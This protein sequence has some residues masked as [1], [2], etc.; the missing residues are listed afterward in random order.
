MKPTTDQE[1]AMIVP[2]FSG[3]QV[4]ALPCGT[5]YGFWCAGWIGAVPLFNSGGEKFILSPDGGAYVL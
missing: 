5:I 3:L 4:S 2:S 1:P